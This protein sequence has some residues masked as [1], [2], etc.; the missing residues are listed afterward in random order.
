[1][2]IRRERERERECARE[3]ERERERERDIQVRTRKSRYGAR[4]ITP[5][6]LILYTQ[7]HMCVSS[8]GSPAVFVKKSRY[9][10][11]SWTGHTV[12][13]RIFIR[14]LRTSYTKLFGLGTL[15]DV[16]TL[17]ENTLDGE[18]RNCVLAHDANKCTCILE[19]G[20]NV[21]SLRVVARRPLRAT[22]LSLIIMYYN[23]IVK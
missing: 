22:D 11:T 19:I 10:L 16:R 7:R 13:Q 17:D 21:G 12:I 18:T 1:M 3:R 5:W 4:T 23:T 9:V 6:C 8:H 2:Y 20:I 14:I 15:K